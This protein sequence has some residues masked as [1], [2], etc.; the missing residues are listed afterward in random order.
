[1]SLWATRMPRPP[2]PAS[3]RNCYADARITD[4]FSHHSSV[5]FVVHDALRAGRGRHI[6]LLG[7]CP[8]DGLILQRIHGPRV[9]SDKADVAGLADIGEVGILG[10]TPVADRKSVV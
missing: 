5:L 6:G 10:Q 2:P 4:A 8:A 7:Q 3:A 1:M 9:R